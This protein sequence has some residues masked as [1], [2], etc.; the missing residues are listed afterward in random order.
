MNIKLIDLEDDEKAASC[1]I[2]WNKK[3]PKG[4]FSDNFALP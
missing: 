2:V 3:L 1:Y 4:G